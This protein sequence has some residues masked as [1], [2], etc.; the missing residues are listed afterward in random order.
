MKILVEVADKDLSHYE[1]ICDGIVLGL[2][3]FSVLNSVEFTLS[4]IE[5]IC[6]Q[7]L[8]LE[9]FIRLDKNIFNHELTTLKEVLKRFSQL[10]I[11]GVF[12]YDLAVLQL[13]KSLNLSLPLV[14]SQTHM[15]TNY[16]TCDYYQQQGV[17]YALLSKEITLDD[18]KEITSCS[19]IVPIVEVVSKP[20]VAFSRRKLVSNYYQD[21][22]QIGK[23]KLQVLE[24]VSNKKYLVKE[25]KSGTGFLLDEVVNGTSVISDLYQVGIPYILLKE[26][27]IDNF[28]ELVEDTK[29]YIMGNCQDTAYVS[30]YK[31]LGDN[32]GFFFQ[33]TVYRVKKK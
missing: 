27:G 29:T 23:E 10:P 6:S 21:L 14:W 11:T 30:K 25:E 24:K 9:L 2:K 12:F 5:D 32:T 4:E 8:N 33:K 20:S 16:R 31:K 28:L 13:C 15:V 18:I 7:S 19:Q 17:R 1:N 3:D 26:E 22:G